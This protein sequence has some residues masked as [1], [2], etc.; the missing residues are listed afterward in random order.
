VHDSSSGLGNLLKTARASFKSTGLEIEQR[1]W[2]HDMDE[3]RGAMQ[4]TVTRR[5]DIAHSPTLWVPVLVW[6]VLWLA[7]HVWRPVLVWRGFPGLESKLYLPLL[8]V[9]SI[10]V[11][12]AGMTHH[13]RGLPSILGFPVTGKPGRIARVQRRGWT[14]YA[15]EK[16]DNETECF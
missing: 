5:Q 4:K 13:G 7:K 2:R 3:M 9:H 12:T 8:S 10:T 11:Q 16:I 14:E 15:H 6:K 1:A